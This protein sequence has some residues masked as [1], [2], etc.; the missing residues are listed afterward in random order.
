VKKKLPI[1]IQNLREMREEGYYYVDKTEFAHR[2]IREGKY[3]FLSRPRRF[4]KSL[5]LDTLK[6]IFEGNEGLFAGLYIHDK[7]EWNKKHPVIRVSFSDGVLKSRQELDAKIHEILNYQIHHHG[8]SV[9]NQSVS[10]KFEDLIRNVHA[11]HGARAVI[12]IDE[13]DKPILDNIEDDSVAMEMREGLKNLY[14]VIKGSDPH[15]KFVM[16]TGV[17]KFSKVSLF[18][19]MNNL[20]DIT[21]EAGFS[22]LCGYTERD[23]DEVFGSELEGL[24]R[25]KVREWYNGYNWLGE[26][27]Y[28]PFDLLLLFRNREF[29]PYWFET[30]TPTFLIKLLRERETWLPGLDQSYASEKLLSTFDVGNIPTEA[31]MF[32]AGYLTIEREEKFSEESQITLKFPNREVYQSLFDTLLMDLTLQTSE[33]VKSRFKLWKLLQK[34]DVYGIGK[35]LKS[36]FASIPYQWHT[37]NNIGDYEGYYASVFYAYFASLGLDISVEE[38]SC[39]GRLDMAVKF[40]GHIYIFEFK[41][42]E[43]EP[44]GRALEQIKAGNY[45]GKYSASGQPIHLIGVEFSREKKQIVEFEV[46]TV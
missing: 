44:V 22:S 33:V 23:V 3:Y 32:Q 18:S 5:F 1:G 42:V 12:L 46:E 45:A 41:V 29:K 37:K 11:Q 16:L 39:A 15:L 28:N 20:T 36:F 13:Y 31:L 19:G 4:G 14:S 7:W 24:D 10:G 43:L 40:N 6:E 35:L 25:D 30:G 38:S 17:S 34:N 21:M 26:A 27:V 9:E 2:L 8:V